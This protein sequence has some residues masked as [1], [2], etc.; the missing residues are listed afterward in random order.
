M[1]ACN[2]MPSS[3]AL[4]RNAS[5][6][7][8]RS[9]GSHGFSLSFRYSSRLRRVCERR[10]STRFHTSAATTQAAAIAARHHRHG[11]A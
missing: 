3:K 7:W 11:R 9:V 2:A 10:T 5:S 6:E 8:N 4:A 1:V